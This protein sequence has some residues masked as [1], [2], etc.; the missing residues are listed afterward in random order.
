[1]SGYYPPGVSGLEPQIT[2]EWPVDP[3]APFNALGDG[4]GEPDPKWIVVFGNEEDALGNLHFDTQAEAER[5]ADQ[6]NSVWPR[7]ACEMKQRNGYKQCP[8]CGD[9]SD[10]EYQ[11]S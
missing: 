3:H 7:R 9:I 11:S 8:T 6:L 4:V 1:M 10:L 5:W 2:G